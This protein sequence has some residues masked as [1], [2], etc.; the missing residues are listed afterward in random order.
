MLTLNPTET[1]QLGCTA[2]QKNYCNDSGLFIALRENKTKIARKG[3]MF[4]RL[5]SIQ[6]EATA[7]Q[8]I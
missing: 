3:G 8:E 6:R 2:L 4:S 1:K 7:P 5:G